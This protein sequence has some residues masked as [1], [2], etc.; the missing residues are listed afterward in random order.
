MNSKAKMSASVGNIYQ[1]II[2]AALGA[3]GVKLAGATR[4]NIARR[5]DEKRHGIVHQRIHHVAQ[6]AT[7]DVHTLPLLSL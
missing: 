3:G 6:I 1:L 2:L 4:A 7:A 5:G